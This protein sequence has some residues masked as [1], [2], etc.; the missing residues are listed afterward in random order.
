VI[1]CVVA[2][3][4]GIGLDIMKNILMIACAAVIMTAGVLSAETL[5]V[6]TKSAPPFAFKNSAGVW[7]GISID[8]WRDIARELHVDY[9]FREY[10]LKDLVQ[11]VET[12][13]VDVAVAALS[14]TPDREKLFDFTHA[15]YN[16]GLGIAVSSE[17]RESSVVHIIKNVL[18]VQLLGYIGG[19]LLLL[20]IS[21]MVLWLMERR[22]N[23]EKFGNTR[24]GLAN[25]FWWSAVTMTTVGYGDVI[26]KSFR[27]RMLGILWM[28][29]AVIVISFFTAGITSS[30]TVSQL[31][32]K[33]NGPR[34]LPGS[35]AGSVRKSSSEL[36]LTRHGITPVY[37]PTVIEGLR[38][39]AGGKIDAMVYDHAILKYYVHR[40]FS[41][42]VDVL[43]VTFNPQSYG[44]ALPK[45]SGLREILNI[46]ILSKKMDDVY[47]RN[48]TERYLGE[49]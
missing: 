33:V 8:L 35:V 32:S 3:T 23:P 11:A 36:Y 12:G 6:G 29:T 1:Y 19:L 7:Q 25:G 5:I 13:R 27:G 24:E 48:L 45:K 38:D 15:Y 47:W 37:F 18:N 42:K 22:V 40:Q 43:D 30:L 31:R 26:P 41:G 20:F 10:N 2:K 49:L 34:D 14:I 17:T 46:K 39:V 21:G 44:F 16:T 28:F 9:R 4:F